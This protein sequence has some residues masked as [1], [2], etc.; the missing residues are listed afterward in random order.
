MNED[1]NA[2]GVISA[3]GRDLP[4]MVAV[5]G[6]SRSKCASCVLMF[7]VSDLWSEALMGL[8]FLL[9]VPFTFLFSL[10]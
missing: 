7:S 2:Y 10:P 3:V 1:V 8:I 9:L 4:R 6:V 5:V